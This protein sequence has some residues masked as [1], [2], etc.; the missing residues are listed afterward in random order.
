MPYRLCFLSSLFYLYHN[1]NFLLLLICLPYIF[2]EE[3]VQTFCFKKKPNCSLII[4]FWK[5]FIYYGY[6]YFIKYVI[7]KYFLPVHSLSFHFLKR[8]DLNSL[9]VICTE[10]KVTSVTFI[11]QNVFTFFFFFSNFG[12]KSKIWSV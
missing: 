8:L 2:R 10:K 5:L 9:G 12:I 7:H 6:K 3:S 4:E 11:E 1:Y